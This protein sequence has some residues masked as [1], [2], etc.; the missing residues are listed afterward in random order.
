MTQDNEWPV[1]AYDA[2]E[3]ARYAL[4]S[5]SDHAQARPTYYD[6]AVALQRVAFALRVLQHETGKCVFMSR[7]R[8]DVLAFTVRE[9]KEDEE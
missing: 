8:D 9:G 4:E 7:D 5:E 6:L 3:V 2:L 1:G